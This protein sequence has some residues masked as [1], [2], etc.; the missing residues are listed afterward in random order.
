MQSFKD[1]LVWLFYFLRL[2]SEKWDPKVEFVV[3]WYVSARNWSN[4][5]WFF[6]WPMISL[7]KT[8]VKS[9]EDWLWYCSA[10][11][12]LALLLLLPFEFH[13]WNL[14]SWVWSLQSKWDP[15]A[16]IKETLKQSLLHRERGQAKYLTRK[17][18]LGSSLEMNRFFWLKKLSQAA[19]FDYN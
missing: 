6:D 10:T 19:V 9:S 14:H 18:G 13:K 7:V 2:L 3:Q 12:R 11:I 16:R 17:R 15:F 1:Y 4:R 8:V 5:P